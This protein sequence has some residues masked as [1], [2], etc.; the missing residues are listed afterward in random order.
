MNVKRIQRRLDIIIALLL[1]VLALLFSPVLLPVVA[2]VGQFFLPAV[3]LAGIV[4][5]FLLVVLLLGT[6]VFIWV[7]REETNE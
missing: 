1:L 2:T 5:P 3:Q 4:G 6:P 7:T